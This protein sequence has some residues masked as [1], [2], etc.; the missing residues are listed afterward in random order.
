[1][2]PELFSSF[3]KHHSGQLKFYVIFIPRPP[4][5]LMLL[6]SLP[7][8]QSNEKIVILQLFLLKNKTQKGS[9]VSGHPTFPRTYKN[10]HVSLF[11][12]FF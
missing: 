9:V 7:C 2:A 8:S 12:N 4:L 5:L 11:L 3:V 6:S 10:I 1:M